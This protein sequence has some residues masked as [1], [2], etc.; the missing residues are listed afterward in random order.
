MFRPNQPLFDAHSYLYTSKAI[1]G[2]NG[3]I[4]TSIFEPLSS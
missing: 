1:V 3:E 2:V 4:Y